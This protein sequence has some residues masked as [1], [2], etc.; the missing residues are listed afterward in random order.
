VR[1]AR[2]VPSVKT[3]GSAKVTFKVPKSPKTKQSKEEEEEFDEED[4]MATSFLQFWSV[5]NIAVS[6]LCIHC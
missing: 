5:A 4:D 6:L 1:A 3:S 2:S